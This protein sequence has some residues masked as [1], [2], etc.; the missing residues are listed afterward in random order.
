MKR[1][2]MGKVHIT[3]SVEDI[4]TYNEI[5]GKLGYKRRDSW[6]I[7]PNIKILLPSRSL[8]YHLVVA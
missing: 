8:I 4:K 3:W 2:T 7:S 5:E 1:K 6:K